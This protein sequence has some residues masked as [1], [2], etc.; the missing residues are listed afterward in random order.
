MS[1]IQFLFWVDRPKVRRMLKGPSLTLTWIGIILRWFISQTV[2]IYIYVFSFV[3]MTNH[4]DIPFPRIGKLA[5]KAR[6]AAE[7]LTASGIKHQEVPMHLCT[8][9]YPY[10]FT[11]HSKDLGFWYPHPGSIGQAVIKNLGEIY[12]TLTSIVSKPGS[13]INFWADAG[14]FLL[15]KQNSLWYDRAIKIWLYSWTLEYG[16]QFCKETLKVTLAPFG[17]LLLAIQGVGGH[18]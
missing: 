1:N 11:L 6:S 7:S 12:T 16:N 2:Y 9:T 15:T 13:P 14:F 18:L 8:K 3:F 10:L 5:S 4:I 17:I